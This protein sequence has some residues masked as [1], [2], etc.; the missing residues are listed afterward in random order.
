M[1]LVHIIIF[2]IFGLIF[3]SF[4][5]VVGLRIPKNESILTPGSHCTTCG[6]S[7]RPF[8]LIPILSYL[9]L[10]GRCRKCKT[11]VSFLYPFIELSTAVLFTI[12]FLAVGWSKEL[13]LLLLFC[14]LLMI[15]L[16]SDLVYMIIPDKV[17]LFFGA[18]FI[19]YHVIFPSTPWWEP[20]VG[21]VVGFTVLLLIAIVSNG[22]MGGG[23]IKLFA[24][25]GFVLG[26][27]LVLLTLFIASLIGAVVGVI[28]M[29]LKKVKRGEPIPFGPFIVIGALT[30]IFIGESLLSWYMNQL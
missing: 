3:G 2:A 5:N 25:L 13:P 16:V 21:A 23:D 15:I 19:I 14:S 18:I 29:S 27:K 4:F 22:G 8:D 12:S 11:S 7:L 20:I 9:F 17:L 10:R 1:E 30:S 28:G 6:Y 26:W 24:V